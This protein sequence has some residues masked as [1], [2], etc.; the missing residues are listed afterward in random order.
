[1]APRVPDAGVGPSSGVGSPGL[2]WGSRR[3]LRSKLTS[4]SFTGLKYSAMADFVSL[5]VEPISHS[6]RNSAIMAVMKSA[7]AIF[8]APPW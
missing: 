1:M 6:T 8:Q 7:S 4:A 2:F 3:P 5:V